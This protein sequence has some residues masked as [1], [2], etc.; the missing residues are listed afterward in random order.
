MTWPE[1]CPQETQ[2]NRGGVVRTGRGRFWRPDHDHDLT[3]CILSGVGFGQGGEGASPRL[4]MH[5][6]QFAVHGRLPVTEDARELGEGRPNAGRCLEQHDRIRTRRRMTDRTAPLWSTPWQ[7][8]E[9]QEWTRNEPGDAH[10]GDHG[11]RARHRGDGE[12]G[13]GRCRDQIVARIGDA[14]AAGIGDEG[15]VTGGEQVQ[16]VVASGSLVVGVVADQRRGDPEVAE[17]RARVAGI[18]RGDQWHLPQHAK[19]PRGDVFKVPDRRRNEVKGAHNFRLS[20]TPR[21]GYTRVRTSTASAS[22]TISIGSCWPAR[23]RAEGPDRMSVPSL[24]GFETPSL[25]SSDPTTVEGEPTADVSSPTGIIG[26]QTQSLYRKYRPQTFQSVDLVGQDHVVQTLRNAIL[27]DRIAHAYLFCGPRGT[28]KT[29]T[30]RLLAKAVNCLDPDPLCRPCNVCPSCR[31]IASGAAT[32]VIEIDAAS[33][34][35]IDDIRDLRERVKYAPTQ[36]KT[37]FYIIDEAHQITGPA[38]NA[39]LK[40]LEEPPAH[41][42][43][44]LA[45]TDPE[46]LLP[47]IVSRCQRFDFRRI[48]LDPMVER[49]RTVAAAEGLTVEED[50]F[51]VIA[52]HATGSLRDALGLLDQLA[53]YQEQE[54]EAGGPI[55]ADAVRTLLGVSRNERVETLVE[56]LASRDPGLALGTVNAAVEAG[57]DPRQINRQLVAY[58]RVLLHQRAGGSVDA[59]NRARALAERFD[60]LELA[61]LTRRFGEIDYKIRHAAFAQLPLEVTLVEGILRRV[62]AAG[63]VQ[64]VPSDVATGGPVPSSS[65]AGPS[66]PPGGRG[67]PSPGPTGSAA[68]ADEAVAAHRPPSTSLRD[69]VRGQS[70]PAARVPSPEASAPPAPSAS[71]PADGNQESQPTGGT[72]VD[73][74]A[75]HEGGISRV[76]SLD[77]ERVADLWPRIRQ[78]VKAIN[79]RIEALLSSVDPTAVHGDHIILVAAYEFHRNRLNADDVR[80]VVEQAIGRL[81][82]HPVR[83]S[84]VLRG[85]L[86]SAT[87]AAVPSAV[88]PAQNLGN[89]PDRP[90]VPSVPFTDPPPHQMSEPSDLP[91]SDISADDDDRRLQ[92]A[93]NIFDAEEIGR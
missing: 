39:F 51:S 14:G 58:L 40:T 30:A 15:E 89:A 12:T 91:P 42:K 71:A 57:E 27:L 8:P 61:D 52:R 28:G 35:G 32:D 6:G 56:A 93:K 76:G 72:P 80:Q 90:E 74:P 3:A 87:L 1:P 7:E 73:R 62:G 16:Q 4:L 19:R 84:C 43:F 83:I 75:S 10:G 17:H 21:T 85:E 37:K 65:S 67:T 53:V 22:T 2:E 92:A 31:A 55:S 54:A 5:L 11:R 86:P 26:S 29:T 46:E 38:A 48:A 13:S 25:Q 77:V 68:P 60:L 66:T 33:N 79:R 50:A 47:T 41:T 45:T 36:L 63:A 9:D 88:G 18:L 49:L 64:G 59:D 44:V 82:G 69:R 70:S 81:V 20:A 34:R 23:S 78:D 24:F